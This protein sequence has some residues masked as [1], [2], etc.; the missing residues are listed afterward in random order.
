MLAVTTAIKVLF[1]ADGPL[2][3]AASGGLWFDVVPSTSNVPYIVFSIVDTVPE[4]TFSSDMENL[5]VQ[6]R[7]YSRSTSSAECQA[8]FELLKTVYD[9]CNIAP[10]GFTKL[11]MKR[12]ISHVESDP[13]GGWNYYVDY[14]I[15]LQKV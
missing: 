7:I 8:I 13:D 12:D 11:R 6:F 9:E 5:R 4:W 3:A 15:W 1:T 10:V 14:I 2:S